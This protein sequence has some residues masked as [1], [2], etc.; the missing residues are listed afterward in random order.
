MKPIPLF[1]MG[2]KSYS[3]VVTAARR[4][5]CFYDIR[6]DGDSSRIIIR[7]TPGSSI[8]VT[9]PTAPIRGYHVIGSVLYV[10]SGVTIYSIT[11]AGV[12]TA[13]G[14]MPTLSQNVSMDDNGVQIIVVDGVAGYI[15]TLATGVVAPITDANFPNGAT[16]VTFLDGKF[17]C[18]VPGGR[19][20]N[21]SASYDG[22]TWSPLIFGTKENY[23]DPLLAVD[24]WNGYLVLWGQYSIE[25]WQDAG[26]SPLPYQRVQG[27]TQPYGLAAL[28]S[29]TNFLN[30]SI[31]MAQS[32]EGDIQIMTFDGFNP[33]RISDSDIENLIND[34]SDK[35]IVYSDATALT[36]M[37]DGHA[38]YQLSFP[39][40][41][42]TV[43][44]DSLTGFWYEVQT[45]LA[46]QAA[47]Y[48]TIGTAFGTMNLFSDGI[49]PNIYQFSDDVF[50]DNG[51]PIKRQL[52]SRHVRDAGNH[53]TIAEVNLGVETGVGLQSGQGS[54]PQISMEVSRD[55]GRTFKQPRLKSMG[56]AGQYRT[57]RV[58]WRRCGTSDDFVFRFTMTDPVKF[59]ITEASA[60][61]DQTEGVNQP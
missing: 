16:S 27:A 39:T 29:R 23:S 54:D 61:R 47:H 7:G 19:Q 34:F 49:T 1:G 22:S 4:L 2:T 25:F 44:Y 48:G 59:T 35:G 28:G 41:G 5:N 26:L 36:Y 30:S 18:N 31:F 32:T 43:L 3:E 6:A 46:V 40:A 60:N 45:G 14:N 17:I 57:P 9:L 37:Q 33:V 10:C 52:V 24:S 12:I 58:N 53:F 8:W 42:R 50:T 11:K 21:V 15:L 55:R 51:T 56:K 13:L 38:M 20:F